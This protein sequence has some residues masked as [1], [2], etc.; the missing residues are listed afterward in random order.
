MNRERAVRRTLK[1]TN[2]LITGGLG[3]VGSNLAEDLLGKGCQVVLVSR[4]DRKLKNI[5]SFVNKVKLEYGDVTDF[6][7]LQE[8]VLKH[9]PDVIFHLAGQLTSYESFEKPLYDVDAN[10]K[11]TIALLE[12]VRKLK[13]PC[14]FI[15]GSTFWVV[16]R[17]EGLSINEETPCHPLNIYAANRLASEHYCKIYN[18]VYDV[19]S[20]VMRLANTFG[21]KEQHDNP[22]K[23]ALNALIYKGYKGETIQIYSEGKFF[24]DYIYISD[25]VS[26]AQIIMEK[27]KA[28]ECYFVGSGVKTWFYEIG[29]WLEE[30]TRGKVAYIQA[31]DYHKRINVGNVVVDNTRIRS[32]GWNWQVSVKDGIKRILEYYKE[33][34]V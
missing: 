21:I 9:K 3:F 7:W 24:R 30:L 31:P 10:S 27:A 25:I 29:Q 34:G 1:M 12:T 4:S 5:A 15:L 33:I 2:V 17:T 6:K 23:A 8:T 18:E 13:T 22:R 14:R 19:D 11:S 20:L 28:G 26:A 32:L 16:G